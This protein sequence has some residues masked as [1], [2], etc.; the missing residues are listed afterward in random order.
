MRLFLHSSHAPITAIQRDASVPS[1]KLIPSTEHAGYSHSRI[2]CGGRE[3]EAEPPSP[4]PPR[5]D[6]R[7]ACHLAAVSADPAKSKLSRLCR[8]A[9]RP[10]RTELLECRL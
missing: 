1:V 2:R 3:H 9:H 7:F 6:G 8:Y 5:P 4:R 10:G